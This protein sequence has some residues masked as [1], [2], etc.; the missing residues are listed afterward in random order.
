MQE[1]HHIRQ[2]MS[3][4][5]MRIVQLAEATKEMY[6]K[7]NELQACI[8]AAAKETAELEKH[9]QLHNFVIPP[10]AEYHMMSFARYFFMLWVTIL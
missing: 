6:Q 2:M 4:A 10:C 5:Q 7:I 1:L 9:L 3:P 8:V